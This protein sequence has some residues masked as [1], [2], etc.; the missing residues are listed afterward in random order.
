[1]LLRGW[2]QSRG[3]TWPAPLRVANGW[4]WRQ[5]F[6]LLP[7]WCPWKHITQRS[8]DHWPG[9]CPFC[10]PLD[11]GW[12][13]IRLNRYYDLPRH[14]QNRQGNRGDETIFEVSGRVE[15]VWS[16]F[17]NCFQRR[18]QERIVYCFLPVPIHP[19]TTTQNYCFCV[20]WFRSKFAACFNLKVWCWTF[21][22]TYLAPRVGPRRFSGP[23]R[24]LGRMTTDTIRRN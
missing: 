2:V 14:Q 1:M 24:I 15:Q 20:R 13:S 6:R 21:P 3:S 18:P 9:W 12:V 10:W 22:R 4:N 11:A 16:H 8:S 5:S 17:D 23:W 19:R 7:F